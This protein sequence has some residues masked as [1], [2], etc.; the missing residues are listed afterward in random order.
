MMTGIVAGN[1]VSTIN[2]PFYNGKKI[3]WVQK[4]DVHGSETGEYIIAIDAVDAGVGD[5]VLI[6]DEGTGARQITGDPTAP[7]RAII[8]GIIDQMD[9]TG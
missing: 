8:V 9:V 1:L 4:T 2:H 7:L 3:M 6:L 5:A